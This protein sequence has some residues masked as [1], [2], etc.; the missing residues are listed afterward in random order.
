MSKNLKKFFL[1]VTQQRAY[2][3]VLIN[4]DRSRVQSRNQSALINLLVAG[5]KLT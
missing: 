4:L 2:T 3:Y 1:K 5:R